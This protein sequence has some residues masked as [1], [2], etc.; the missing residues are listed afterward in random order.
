MRI[1]LAKVLVKKISEEASLPIRARD[2]DAGA[3]LVAI[4]DGN[5]GEDGYI[6]YRTGISIELPLGYHAEIWPR[7]SISKY[8]LVLANGIGLID[9]GYRGEIFIRFKP[10]A[11]Y[12]DTGH[13]KVI[14]GSSNFVP[15]IYKKGDKIAQLV[16]SETVLA[17]F[18]EAFELSETSRGSGGFGSTGS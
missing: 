12:S 6:Q 15:N 2:S 9:N 18:S 13:R 16:I 4:D 8:D 7:S 5:V 10:V 11:R 3:D 1:N 17:S 14:I